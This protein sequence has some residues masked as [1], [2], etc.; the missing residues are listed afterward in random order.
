M[1]ISQELGF[2]TLWKAAKQIARAI[3]FSLL[4]KSDCY[5]IV[6]SRNYILQ[7]LISNICISC[8]DYLDNDTSRIRISEK[9]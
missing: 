2:W 6:I 3:T 4:L 7:E 1:M 8:R 5:G 9:N